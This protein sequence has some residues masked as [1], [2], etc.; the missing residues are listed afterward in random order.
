MARSAAQKAE[1]QGRLFW[2]WLL[3]L[4]IIF[5]LAGSWVLGA[6]WPSRLRLQ[7]ALAG[8]AFPVVFV[9]GAPLFRNAD[10]ARR[11]GTLS[12]STV[13]AAATVLAYASGVVALVA[14]TPSLAGASAVV[15]SAY[16]TLR[17][18]FDWD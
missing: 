13:V 1:E 17:Y 9:V 5:L 8:L 4:P 2:A 11:R 12:G 14:P 18:C 15:V 6:P 10:A 3:T 7:L 16:L